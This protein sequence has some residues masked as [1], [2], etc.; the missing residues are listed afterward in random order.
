MPSRDKTYKGYSPCK[1]TYN[2]INLHTFLLV[3]IKHACLYMNV[4][5]LC[6]ISRVL[7]NSLT[8]TYDMYEKYFKTKAFRFF[9]FFLNSLDILQF[10]NKVDNPPNF[11]IV[12]SIGQPSDMILYCTGHSLI[13]QHTGQSSEIKYDGQ[14]S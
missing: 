13:V 4:Y 11:D 1:C 5:M 7:T 12:I 3:H 9:L 14:P 8:L 2:A 10:Y 6:P